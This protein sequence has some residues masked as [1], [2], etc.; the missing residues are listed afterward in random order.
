MP[1]IARVK[2]AKKLEQNPA[3]TAGGFDVQKQ[4]KAVREIASTMGFSWDCGRMGLRAAGA[5]GSR[6]CGSGRGL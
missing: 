4:E 2:A 1:L 3:L 6:V 5:A